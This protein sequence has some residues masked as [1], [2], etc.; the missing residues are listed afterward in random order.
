MQPI[1]IAG[2]G[3][4]TLDIL[5][6]LK[7]MPTW[8]NGGK[9]EEIRFDGG[10]PVGT[11]LV[12]ASRLGI[13]TG[14]MGTRGNDFLGA[15]K[16]NL[17]NQEGVDTSQVVTRDCPETHIIMVYIDAVS[18]ERIFCS[19]EN[20]GQKNLSLPEFNPDYLSSVDLLH[21]DGFA[22][23]DLSLAAGHTMHS[24]GKKV[25]LDAGKTQGAVHAAMR[26]LV[27]NCDYLVCGSGFCQAL[28]G[29]QPIKSAGQAILSM[30]PGV[31]VQTEGEEGSCTT[32]V[33]NH[34]HTPAFKVNCVDTT[35]AGDVFHGAYLVGL[36]KGWSL[37][38]IAT[39]ASAV[40]ALKC[41]RMGGRQGIPRFIEVENFL[42][43]RAKD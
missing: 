27:E 3:L 16:I 36:L 37:E 29:I 2:L 5:M 40:S 13:K 34:F 35:G 1:Q 4:A 6:R 26:T 41:T 15:Y 25:M 8:D 32:T 22:N 18:G 20:F 30:G 38:R 43:E 39:F 28:T 24:A 33:D 19:A 12:A 11:A 10:G 14:F 23:L 31:V 17:F 21:L 7:S 9:M 42:K